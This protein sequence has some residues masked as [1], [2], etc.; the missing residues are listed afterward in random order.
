[1]T[2]PIEIVLDSKLGTSINGIDGHKLFKLNNSILAKKDEKILFYLKKLFLPFSFYCISENQKNN[3]LDVKEI[4]SDN[5]ENTYS[6]TVE[7]GNPDIYSLI[8]EIKSLLEANSTFNYKYEI[9]Y[10]IN[11]NKISIKLLSGD[12]ALKSVIL[13]SSGNNISQSINNVLGFASNSDLEILLNNTITS[14]NQV[15][16]ADGLDSVHIK[17][18]LVGNNIRSVDSE[19]NELLIIPLDKS[20]Y[21]IIYFQDETPFKHLLNVN[22]ITNIEL[23]LQDSNQNII[24]MN[25]IPYTIILQCEFIKSDIIIEEDDFNSNSVKNNLQD[26]LEKFQ[27]IKDNLNKIK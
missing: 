14:P 1:M 18:N 25:N 3:K 26:N 10:N 5:T 4:Q 8:S 12:L 19:S 15:D 6:I 23:I 7:D 17:S 24:N 16:L 22:V 21:S 11:N 2:L 9:T 20:P 27:K 13:F